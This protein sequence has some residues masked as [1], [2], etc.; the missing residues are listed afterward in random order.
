MNAPPYF[1]RFPL[2]HDW[3]TPTEHPIGSVHTEWLSIMVN[4]W[5]NPL[6]SGSSNHA[7]FPVTV[8]RVIV[9]VVSVYPAAVPGFSLL[10]HTVP[11]FVTTLH[12]PM[13]QGQM[14]SGHK[15]SAG[16]GANTRLKSLS[17]YETTNQPLRIMIQ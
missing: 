15:T 3:H 1:Y 12:L 5:I 13:V 11:G 16:H 6:K 9:A 17:Q 4:P 10:S 2:G 14:V 8:L 7:G